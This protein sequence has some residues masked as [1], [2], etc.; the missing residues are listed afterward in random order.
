M[1]ARL[2][3]K[4]AV[5][6]FGVCVCHGRACDADPRWGGSTS[7]LARGGRLGRVR[8][9][10]PRNFH[11]LVAMRKREIMRKSPARIHIAIFLSTKHPPIIP[12]P[13]PQPDGARNMRMADSGINQL[14]KYIP[15]V[16]NTSLRKKSRV[17]KIIKRGKSPQNKGSA[18]S[19]FLYGS[20][21]NIKPITTPI[22]LRREKIISIF[23]CC[24]IYSLYYPAI[25][26]P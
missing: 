8:R 7:P 11:D 22:K 1:P 13:P 25:F 6:A 17:R 16:W 4:C 26:S 23:L 2:H 21:A 20:N 9:Y 14:A 12:N 19:S 15:H 10:L 5:S 24:F 3:L 18:T